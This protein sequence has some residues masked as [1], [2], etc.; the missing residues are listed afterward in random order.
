MPIKILVISFLVVAADQ[1]TKALALKFLLDHS[2]VP[3]LPGILHL[4]LVRNPGVAFGLFNRYGIG[5]AVIT[6]FILMGLLWSTLKGEKAPG[7]PTLTL[8]LILGGAM[9]NLIDRVRFGSVVDFLDFRIWPVF[10]V[11]DSC[12]TVGAIVMAISL[13]YEKKKKAAS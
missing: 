8:G 3:I 2:T 9:G 6:T 13:L 11:A 10:N 4:T 12:I 1:A 5:V 7:Y